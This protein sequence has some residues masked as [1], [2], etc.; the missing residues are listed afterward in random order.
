[1]SYLLKKYDISLLEFEFIHTV[2]STTVRIIKV[3]EK[4]KG[5]FPLDCEIDDASLFKW[6]KNRTIPANRAYVQNFL[7]RNGL[8]EKDTEGIINISKGLSLNDAYWVVDSE[9]DGKFADYNLYENRFSRVLSLIAFTGYGSYVGTSF[10]S[11][12]EFTTGGMLAKCWRRENGKIVLYKAGTEG[13]ANA[14]LEPYSEYYAYQIAEKMG[15]RAVQYGLSK[16]KGKLC[17]TCE[18]FNDKS[19]SY[20]SAGKL[21]KSGGIE[22]LFNYYKTLGESFYNDL[23]DMLVFDALIYNED[24]HLGNFGFLVDNKKNKIIQTAPLYD[25]GLSLFCYAMDDDLSNIEKYAGT[26]APAL[27]RSFDELAGRIM[28]DRQRKMLAK[29]SGFHFSKHSR[30]NW[31]EHRI[32]IIEKFLHRRAEELISACSTTNDH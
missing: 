14:G 20:V 8:N 16:W 18:L 2:D 15:I 31:Q 26:R 30:Y 5:Q 11:S 25:H 7:A 24:R 29:L 22:V 23:I 12:P 28:T 19:V 21:I 10:R 27:Y 9:F 17:S 3:Y 13:F 4:N 6:L 32:E 1:M